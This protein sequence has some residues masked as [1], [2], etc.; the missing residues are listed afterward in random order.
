MSK[1]LLARTP[2][3]A[4]GYLRTRMHA[5]FSIQIF[6]TW[7]KGMLAT[8]MGIN[9]S[10]H[11]LAPMVVIKSHA[12]FESYL[13]KEIGVSDWHQIT[14]QQINQFADATLDHQWIHIDTERAKKESPFKATIAHGYLTLSLIPY[15][16]KQVADVQNLKM[17]VNYG[18]EQLKFGQ[19]VIV[20]SEVRCRVSLKSIINLKGITKATL[21]IK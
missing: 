20:N 15:F 5:L 12:E 2:T 7:H 18:I 17:E 14:Q 19:A 6:T 9:K 1:E 21:F 3:A 11:I 16:W 4:R 13:G 10:F 8:I